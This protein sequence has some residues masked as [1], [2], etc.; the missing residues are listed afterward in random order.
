[1]EQVQIS[2][3]DRLNSPAM[4]AV[5]ACAILSVCAMCVYF[6]VKSWRAGVAVGMDKAVLK[7]AV[8]SS[9]TFTLLPAFSVLRAESFFSEKCDLGLD[10]RSVPWYYCSCR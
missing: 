6:M 4:Y 10:I 8:V 1:M 5:V 7:K 2:L 9:A 3:L